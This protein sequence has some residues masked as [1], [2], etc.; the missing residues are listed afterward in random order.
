LRSLLREH[1][2]KQGQPGSSERVLPRFNGR[3]Y[4]YRHFDEVLRRA[5]LAGHTP[6]DLRDTFASWLVSLRVP[7]AWVSESLGHSLQWHSRPSGRFAPNSVSASA[8]LT[9]K[10]ADEIRC[11]LS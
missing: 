11:G 5:G 8:I 10:T 2:V 7:V 1:W 4:R 6:K 9:L 3:N